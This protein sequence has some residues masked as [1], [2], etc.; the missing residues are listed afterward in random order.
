ML[1]KSKTHVRIPR[2]DWERLRKHPQFGELVEFLEDRA[3]LEAAKRVRGKDVTLG[4][5]LS[6]RGIQNNS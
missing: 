5:Y 2:K 6:K 4:Q 3:D 1:T